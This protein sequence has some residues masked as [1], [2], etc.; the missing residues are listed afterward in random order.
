MTLILKRSSLLTFTALH[1]QANPSMK[2]SGSSNCLTQRKMNHQKF[3]ETNGPFTP[4]KP[5]LDLLALDEID[6]LLD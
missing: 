2:Y 1:L 4:T 6:V 5:G 3:S